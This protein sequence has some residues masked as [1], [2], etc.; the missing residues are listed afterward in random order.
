MRDDC[1][2]WTDLYDATGGPKW[3]ACSDKRLD[4]CSCQGPVQK[5]TGLHTA[6]V[7]CTTT[8][9]DTRITSLDLGPNKLVGTVPHSIGNLTELTEFG[10]F[11]N[12]GLASTIPATVGQ[13]TKLQGLRGSIEPSRQVI[14]VRIDTCLL[15][16]PGMDLQ[17]CELVHV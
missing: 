10:I 6:S 4:P 2:A 8:T 16:I 1:Q 13:L 7:T 12:P 3:T 5:S 11:Q 14:N 15:A 9:F 17:R